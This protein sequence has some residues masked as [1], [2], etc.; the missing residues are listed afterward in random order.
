MIQ[1][2]KL[3]GKIRFSYLIIGALAILLLYLALRNLDWQETLT[4]FQTA[5]I[6]VLLGAWVVIVLSYFLR[7]LRWQVLLSAEK[8]LHPVT[9]FW[10]TCVGY[11]GN[12]F[13][14][15][16]AGEVIRSALLSRKTGIP[17][18]YVFATA[19][20]ER[21]FDAV[22]LV[23][24]ILLGLTTFPNIPD[25]LRSAMT[26]MLIL[27]II[28]GFSLTLLPHLSGW[29]TSQ[30]NRLPITE[31]I[32]SKLVEFVQQF[33]LGMKAFQHFSRAGLFIVISLFTWSLDVIATL[34][35]TA[36][37]GIPF[38]PLQGL[39]ILAALGLA[40]A[41]PSTPGY[42]G[43]YQSVSVAIFA[44][45]GLSDEG[46]IVYILT[47]QGLTYTV[48]ILWGFIGLWR[49]NKMGDVNDITSPN[50]VVA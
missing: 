11:L 12:S 30:M 19:L 15:A 16:R 9:V 21:I 10:A 17:L 46:A 33:L 49:L 32:K 37:Y 44:L 26:S 43:I 38:T 28:G 24:A 5:D 50:D 23:C 25:W 18:F 1:N 20:T 8:T 13:L 42:V 2:G 40:S 4:I 34:I 29:I 14:P 36:G 6:R 31:K 35:I 27:G 39:L 48:V 3:F 22:L 7:G 47:T 45:F 41:A